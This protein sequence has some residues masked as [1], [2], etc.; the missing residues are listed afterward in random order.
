[1][2]WAFEFEDQPTFAGFRTLATNGIDKPVLNAFRMFGLLDGER[3]SVSSSG[4]VATDEMLQAGVRGRPDIDAMAVRHGQ[5]LSIL[6]WN[7]QDDDLPAPAVPEW[8]C[9]T[10]PQAPRWFWVEHFRI[11][12]THSNAYTVWKNMGSPEHPSADQQQLLEEAG[13]VAALG[14]AAMDHNSRVAE[15]DL[16]FSLPR[17]GLSLIR[18]AW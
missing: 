3:L 17:Q 16:N 6:V 12:D 14:I 11:D 4:A 9:P 7:Y 13:T 2:T 15:I 18:I 1:M 8:M 5:Q 10:F